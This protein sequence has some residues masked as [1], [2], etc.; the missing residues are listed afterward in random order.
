MGQ[1]EEPPPHPP[2]GKPCPA[3]DHSPTAV[4][5]P[6]TPTSFS[7]RL[8]PPIT[9]AC[10]PPALGDPDQHP[11]L[12]LS[13]RPALALHPIPQAQAGRHASGTAFPLRPIKLRP[14]PPPQ[15]SRSVLM[16]STNTSTSHKYEAQ[17]TEET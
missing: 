4:S 5:Y 10:V 13:A 3:A 11:S 6:P 9:A 14:P 1:A 8:V 2:N 17:G 7:L 15:H 12:H 16:P